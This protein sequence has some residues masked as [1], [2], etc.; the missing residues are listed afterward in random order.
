MLFKTLVPK[1]LVIKVVKEIILPLAHQ[2]VAKTPS[3][4]DNK[5]L[6]FIEAVLF[7]LSV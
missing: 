4:V 7:E 1:W 3:D 6:A 5:V 2:Y